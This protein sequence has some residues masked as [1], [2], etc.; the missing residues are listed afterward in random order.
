MHRRLVTHL[1]NDAK[2]KPQCF[3]H[4]FGAVR[5]TEVHPG[6]HGIHFHWIV[7]GR[8]NLE[9]MRY[10]GRQCGFGHLFIARD[11]NARF[12]AV[13]AGAAGYLAKYLVKSEK[14]HGVRQWACIGDFKGTQ[15][16]DVLFDSR[17]NRM[18]RL[19]YAEAKALGKPRPICWMF[20]MVKTRQWEHNQDDRD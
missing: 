12:R 16:R 2:R 6:G 20:A 8:I 10:R 17:Q 7:R 14:L 19:R 1:N 11:H 9:W 4:G 18:F 3:S 13:D 15:T 5:V